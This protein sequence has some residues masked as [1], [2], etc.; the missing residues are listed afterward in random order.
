MP[1]SDVGMHHG[2]DYHIQFKD[3][4]S[5]EA[6]TAGFIA[7]NVCYELLFT[8]TFSSNENLNRAYIMLLTISFS[9]SLITIL[10]STVTTILFGELRSSEAKTS[11]AIRIYRIKQVLFF[12]SF[13]SLFFWIAASCF[14][15]EV[16]YA[17]PKDVNWCGTSINMSF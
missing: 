8:D 6:W 5:E 15:G 4:M 16:K 12:L 17:T 1:G 9:C 13:G 3:Q 7:G 10:I 14:I 2:V 11:F